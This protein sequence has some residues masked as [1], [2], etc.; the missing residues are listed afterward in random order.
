MMRSDFV[1]FILTHGRADNV[2]TYD[3]LRDSG[4]TGRVILVIDNEDEQA[5]KYI[6]RYGIE[7]VAIFSKE[8]IAKTF[9]EGHRGDRRTI[10]YARNACFGIAKRLGYKHFIELDDDYTTFSYRFRGDFSF[11]N[12]LPI[13]NLDA[14]WTAMLEYYESVPQLLSIA[15][16]QGGDF[17]GG[18]HGGYSKSVRTYRKAMNSFICSVE[19]PFS[20]MGRINEDVNTYTTL[21]HR[22]KLF[23]STNQVHLLQK[24]TQSNKGGMTDV[25]LDSGTY[26]KTFFSVMYHPSGVKVSDIRS[27]HARIHHRISWNNTAPKILRESVRR[28]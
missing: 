4:Y 13:K 22:G 3:T 28:F 10:I 11:T 18:E 19:R 25:Y 6:A 8:E 7:N 26:L 20:F 12:T 17:L 9:D 15:M 16:M 27:N 24:E 14:V 1:A 2:I 21:A 23:L 5:D